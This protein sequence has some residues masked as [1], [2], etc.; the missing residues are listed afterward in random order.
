VF[1]IENY[2]IACCS[3]RDYDPQMADMNEIQTEI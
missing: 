3:M 2:S 1:L